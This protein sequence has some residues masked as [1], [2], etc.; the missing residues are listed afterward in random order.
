MAKPVRK[1]N[2]RRVHTT[3]GKNFITLEEAE[4]NAY[5][6]PDNAAAWRRLGVIQ[7]RKGRLHEAIASLETSGQLNPNEHNNLAWLGYTHT[8]LGNMA[9]AQK[10]L[11]SVL[12]DNPQHLQALIGLVALQFHSG[13]HALTLETLETAEALSPD[14]PE[15]LEYKAQNLMKLARYEEAL[16]VYHHILEQSPDNVRAWNGAGVVYR[17]LGD[18]DKLVEYHKKAIALDKD[19][20]LPFANLLTA[21]HYSPDWG[22]DEIAE[23]CK[24]WQT[25]YAPRQ[26]PARPVPSN[27]SP[28]KIL[29]IGMFSDG[30]RSHPVGNMIIEAVERLHPEEVELYCYP[31]HSDEDHITQRFKKIAAKWQPIKHLASDTFAQCVRDDGIDILIDMSGHNS[32]SRAYSVALQPAPL[33]VKWVGGLINTT[34]IEAI[35]YLLSDSIETPPEEVVD[36]RYVEKLVRLPDDYIVYH[37][38]RNVPLVRSLP[39]KKNGYITLGCFNNPT[40]LNDTTLREWA[41]LMHELPDSR[42]FLKN[43]PYTSKALCERIYATLE[44]EGIARKRVLI[45]GP[46]KHLKLLEAYG[47][48]DI[49]LDPWPYS[50]G[51]TTCESLLMGV[52]VVTLPGPTF[53]GRHSATHLIN[54]GLPE[55]VVDSWEQYRERVIELASD[56]ESLATIRTHLRDILKQSPVCDG[57]RF[58]KHLMIT[59]RAIWQRYCEGKAP[60]ALTFNK[61]GQAW[62][63]G[64]SEPVDVVVQEVKNTQQESS[65]FNWEIKG[66]IVTIDNACKVL[67]NR[68]LSLMIKSRAFAIIAFDPQ[69]LVQ[70]PEVYANSENIQLFQHVLLGDNQPATLY[71]CMSPTLS[72][73]LKPLPTEQQPL[74]KRE[75]TR[76]LTTL[77]INTI[78]LDSIKGI[79]SLDWLVLDG[80][81]DAATILEHG[82]RALTDTLVIELSAVFQPTHERQPSLAEL[83]HWASRNGFRFYCLNTPRHISHLPESIPAKKRQATELESADVLFLPSHARMTTLSDNQRIKLAFLL[84]TVYGIKDMAYELLAEVSQEKAE[85]YLVEEGLAEKMKKPAVTR[86]VIYDPSQLECNQCEFTLCV[87][88]PV[89][90]EEKYIRETLQ[91]LKRQDFKDVRFL[92]SD[93]CSTDNTLNIIREE[94]AGDDRFEIFQQSENI[95][96]GRNFEFVFNNSKSKYFMWLGAH[97]F[98]SDSYLS[99]VVEDIQKSPDASMVMGKPMAVD[100]KSCVKGV[101]H[102]AIYDFSNNK[103]ESRYLKSVAELANCTVFHSVFLRKSLDDFVFRTTI[104]NDHVLISHLLWH[105]KLKNIEDVCYFRRYFYKRSE[106]QEERLAGSNVKLEREGFYKYYLD[107][108]RGLSR[109]MSELSSNQLLSKANEIIR[110]RFG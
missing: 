19:N 26:P 12:E 8:L 75:G 47:K 54:A 80:L 3:R 21:V 46:A 90:N 73:T 67:R 18:F 43:K 106:S 91:S 14:N 20:P 15:L 1:K 44:H 33:L 77:P 60:E 55:L 110:S 57:A 99:L 109:Y 88:V 22:S 74:G 95:G 45:E 13:Q 98:L 31:T 82:Q 97:D 52:P 61:D 51:L 4:R 50:G 86:E 23:L 100:E 35:D 41:K 24:E 87:G 40:K 103:K 53:A 30:F 48:V 17:D 49:A 70:K 39:A 65:G 5:K 28:A 83:Q 96:A 32:G 25:R 81:S 71:V 42:L 102:S 68:A 84:H 56:L 58:A 72:S 76:L 27:L 85:E 92:V 79:A 104:S 108:L 34:G 38:P 59:L 94:V 11:N 66:Q 105:G 10:Y 16:D 63:K 93:N 7:M 36:Q 64:E 37:I 2:L 9:Q 101:V 107:D 89:Y 69:S 78:A 62:F 29:R 6:N